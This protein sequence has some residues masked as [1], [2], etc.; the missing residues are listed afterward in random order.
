MLESPREDESCPHAVL[1]I[2]VSEALGEFLDHFI[3]ASK[4]LGNY[5]LKWPVIAEAP[6]GVPLDY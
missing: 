3:V 1:M 6:K 2:D 4:R 5:S